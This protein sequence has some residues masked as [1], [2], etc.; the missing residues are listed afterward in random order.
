M[1]GRGRNIEAAGNGRDPVE[2]SIN[3]MINNMFNLDNWTARVCSAVA[4]VACLFVA[5]LG[6]RPAEVSRRRQD[7][8]APP[9]RVEPARTFFERK[10][11]F[12]VGDD[13]GYNIY[14]IPGIVVTA[15][16]TVLAW[17]EARKTRGARRLGRHPNPA[18]P[19]LRRRQD[20][21]R[22]PAA[23]PTCRAR[24]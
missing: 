10:D 12:Q 2:I 4:V 15:R 6:L 13:P 3:N 5:A 19:H 7:P 23:S 11:L 9:H 24:R 17:C 21:E 14:H 22:R 20:L 8:M 1:T 16:G 18:P